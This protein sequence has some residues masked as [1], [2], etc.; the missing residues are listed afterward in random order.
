ML[1]VLIAPHND[2]EVLFTTFL[3]LRYKPHVVVCLRSHKQDNNWAR[4]ELETAAAMEKL[5]CTWEQ[6]QHPDVAP[7]WPSVKRMIDDLAN[8]YERCFAPY[9]RFAANG[10]SNDEP[11][12][13]DGVKQ[14]D[15]IGEIAQESFGEGRYVGYLTYTKAGKDEGGNKVPFDPEWPLLKLEALALYKSQIFRPEIVPHFLGGLQEYVARETPL[16]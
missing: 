3:L 11:Q 9:P 14:H 15:R 4:R 1:D 7:D 6:W 5:G 13:R 16:P 10:W 8:R 12:P 2:D